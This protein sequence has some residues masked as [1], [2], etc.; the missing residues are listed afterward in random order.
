MSARHTLTIPDDVRAVLRESTIGADRVV[1]PLRQ[2]ERKLYNGVIKVLKEYGGTWSR[3]ANAILIKTSDRE[4]LEAELA[5]GTVT[6]TKIVR[7]AF[8]TP[9]AIASRLIAFAFE[10]L[11]DTTGIALLEPSAGGGALVRAAQRKLPGIGVCCV[12]SDPEAARELDRSGLF[13]LRGDFLEC[14]PGPAGLGLFRLVAMNPPFQKGQA[15][16]HFEHALKFLA[17]G[18][19]LAAI[20][21]QNFV[22]PAGIELESEAIEAGAFKESG[23]NIATKMVRHVRGAA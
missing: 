16:K 23:T 6:R 11:G 15:L 17:P 9:D 2:L 22:G 3:A 8:Y 20:V 12:E 10:A 4:R 14:V 5:A 7:Q 13:T 1:L 21:P 19:V 18:G